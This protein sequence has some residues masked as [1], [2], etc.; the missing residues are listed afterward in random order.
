MQQY[1]ELFKELYDSYFLVLLQSISNEWWN[2][3][4]TLLAT[5]QRKQT[6]KM[7]KP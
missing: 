5:W 1:E 6:E 7:I 4:F 2:W 3:R